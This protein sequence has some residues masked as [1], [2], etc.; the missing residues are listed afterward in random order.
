MKENRVLIIAGCSQKKLTHPAPAIN[1]NQGQLFRSIKKVARQNYFDLKILSGKYGLLDPNEVIHPY[2]QEIRT[3]ADIK[4]I[5][6]LIKG[7]IDY[8]W[9]NYD[10]IITIMGRKYQQVM[11]P[12]F[13]NKFHVVFDKRGIGGYLSKVS[14]FS[15]LLTSQFLQEITQFRQFE[16][17]EYLW[18]Y[19][20]FAIGERY[21]DPNC[22][23]TCINCYFQKDSVCSFS[24]LYPNLYQKHIRDYH[25]ILNAR[26]ENSLD[27]KEQI[28]RSLNYFQNTTLDL[29]LTEKKKLITGEKI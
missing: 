12:Y 19:W 18:S 24:E 2:N 27:N 17:A 13:D 21:H 6:D 14:H 23:H 4:R 8:I 11:K 25:A 5:Q 3:K 16:C 9:R 10:L 26:H 20:D 22:P 1:L 15:K 29:F 7:K 28:G